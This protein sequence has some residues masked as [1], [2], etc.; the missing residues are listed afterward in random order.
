MGIKNFFKFIQKYIPSA[1]S[2]KN[3][4]DYSN[5][6]IGFDANLLLYKLIYGIRTRGYDIKS[7]NI[8][9][10]HIH[11]LLL[12]FT[13][14]RK[15]NI[16]PIFVFDAK[17]PQIKFKTLE[18]RQINKQKFISKHQDSKTKEGQRKYYYAKTDLTEQE[19][20]DCRK[21]I[22]LFGFTIIDALEEADAQLVELYKNK[23]IDYIASD[24][25]D[26]LLFGGNI[27]KNFTINKTK[28]IIEIN[29]NELLK[30]YSQKQ[31]I[32]IGLLLGSDYCDNY[33]FSIT[34][35]YNMINNS[36]IPEQCHDAEIYFIAPPIYKITT[37]RSYL[38]RSK[39]NIKNLVEFLESFGLKSE[40]YLPP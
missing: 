31:L 22:S 8:I 18:T 9:I 38:A 21:L 2:Y 40:K 32:H 4:Q 27:L 30:I 17:M 5:K 15:Y 34:K 20:Q 35:T 26:I 6:F 23:L 11:S 12:K 29:L 39:I 1:I 14:F 19:I 7:N 13:G 16:T 36:I 10:T 25:S 37:H 3:I 24:D 28:K 33:N